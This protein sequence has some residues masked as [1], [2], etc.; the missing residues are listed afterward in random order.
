V[1]YDGPRDLFSNLSKFLLRLLELLGRTAFC[2]VFV[3]VWRG[4]K[5]AN[6]EQNCNR[7][8]YTFLLVLTSHTTTITESIIL[9]LTSQVRHKS[10]TTT[11]NHVYHVRCRLLLRAGSSSMYVHH[12]FA[13]SSMRPCNS[14][15]DLNTFLSRQSWISLN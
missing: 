14:H 4:N 2:V 13:T 9:V 1:I 11:I 8:Y 5:M 12:V 15:Y 7:K 3:W 10:H 6:H